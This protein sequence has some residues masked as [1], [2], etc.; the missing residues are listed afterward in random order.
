MA[1]ARL[2]R[3]N[4]R[5]WRTERWQ[6]SS[7]ARLAFS[8]LLA[9]LADFTVQGKHLVGDDDDKQYIHCGQT[10]TACGA[11]ANRTHVGDPSPCAGCWMCFEC[12]AAAF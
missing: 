4:R 9:V 6:L 12:V 3:D 8:R 11:C 2:V 7:E 10:C 1:E 5:G